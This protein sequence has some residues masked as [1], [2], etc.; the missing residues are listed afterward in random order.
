MFKHQTKDNKWLVGWR[1]LFY[2]FFLLKVLF[3]YLKFVERN[4]WSFLAHYWD[5]LS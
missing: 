4:A 5:I 2:F 3:K 1:L